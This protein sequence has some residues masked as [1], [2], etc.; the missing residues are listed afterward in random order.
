MTCFTFSYC[1]ILYCLSSCF[2]TLDCFPWS[3]CGGAAIRNRNEFVRSSPSPAQL[4]SLYNSVSIELMSQRE[5]DPSDPFFFDAPSPPT[6][7][8]ALIFFTPKLKWRCAKDVLRLQVA[9]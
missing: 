6:P 4:N 3:G 5:K 1:C 9:F 2:F 7:H 8:W